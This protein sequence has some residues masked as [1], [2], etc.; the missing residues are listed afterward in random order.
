MKKIIFLII[1]FLII[2]VPNI[3]AKPLSEDVFSV[4]HLNEKVD[5]T[6]VVLLHVKP[7]SISELMFR[8]SISSSLLEV[9]EKTKRNNSLIS[10]F[11]LSMNYRF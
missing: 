2:D 3:S 5:M 8:V 11:V 4:N 10:R 9:E 7:Q 6:P 1:V